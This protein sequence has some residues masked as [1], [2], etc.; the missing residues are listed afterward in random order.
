VTRRLGTRG[1]RLLAAA[2]ALTAAAGVPARAQKPS[3]AQLTAFVDSVANAT[4]A[5]HRTPGIAIAIARGSE[6]LFAKGYGFVD[7]ENDVRT[8]P[9]HVFRIGSITKQFTA[10]AIMQLV[11]QGKLS[12]DDPITK[13]FPDWSLGGQTVTVAQLL[14]HTGG[15]H[16]YTAVPQWRPMQ[17]IDM[18][19]D[20]L[21][22]LVRHDSLDFAP[23]SRYSY[24]NTGYYMLGVI[25]EKVSGQRYADY[26]Q[27][28]IVAPLGLTGTSYCETKPLI[29]HRAQGYSSD[30]KGGWTNASFLSM[31][32]PFAAGSICSTVGDLITWTKAL[33]S[34]KVVKPESYR[35]MTTPIAFTDGTPGQY[36]FG[37]RAGGSL[38]GH[39][40][41]NHGGSINGFLSQKASY[42][43]DSLII[44]VLTN[45]DPPPSNANA[46]PSPTLPNQIETAIA[47]RALGL[48]RAAPK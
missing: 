14:N 40:I 44:V 12:V 19:H 18:S 32:L 33:E 21:L 36:G 41:V 15:V 37:L 31:T 45:A 38:D 7:L 42:P 34:G 29:A 25:I 16:N 11:D 10:A 9:A 28:H 2:L 46:S 39:R 24:S 22:A 13:W 47:R 26:L 48:S 17:A 23:G 3:R 20:S 8:T 30:G 4:I 5:E 1:R 43:D 27:S 6:P 35:R